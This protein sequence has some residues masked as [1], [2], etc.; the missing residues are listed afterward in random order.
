MPYFDGILSGELDALIESFS[1]EPRLRHPIRGEIVGV[2]AFEDFVA[3]MG[4]WFAAHD[5]SA[6]EPDIVIT[7]PRGF[8][9]VLIGFDTDAGRVQLPHALIVEHDAKER[10]EELRIYFSSWPYTGRHTN[11]APLLP[12]DSGL[13][14]PDVVD[15]YQRALA[16]G[17]LDT[18]VEAF[19]PDG[20]AREP[21]G[22]E[23]VHRGSKELRDFYQRQFSNGGGIRQE[24]CSIV[25]GDQ[26]CALEYNLGH[27]GE[28]ELQPSAGVAAYAR[29]DGGRLTAV[30]IYDDVDP[31]VGPAS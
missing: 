31:P 6:G 4:R 10:I 2:R 29:G 16:G 22:A 20:Y 19:E 18:I 5:A 7:E 15:E 26:L 24:L 23:Y 13:P 12:P 8:E 11:R 21:A 28:T 3:D 9:E 14:L 17:D 30:R 27:W 25:E 1:G